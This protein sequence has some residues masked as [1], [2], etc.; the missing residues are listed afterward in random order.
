[1]IPNTG[2]TVRVWKSVMGHDYSAQGLVER[3]QRDRSYGAYLML[4]GGDWWVAANDAE[5][6]YEIIQSADARCR[7]CGEI[8][9]EMEPTDIVVLYDE[10]GH[11]DNG[12][13]FSEHHTEW[14]CSDR[15]ACRGRRRE[16]WELVKQQ[17]HWA[18][19]EA[20]EAG[21]F[22]IGGGVG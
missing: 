10:N 3:L 6:G 16:M 18:D 13:C 21:A 17:A 22:G 9:V 7:L 5:N 8:D 4:V 12:G 1:M 20:R 2:D 19:M 11:L 15:A 14:Q